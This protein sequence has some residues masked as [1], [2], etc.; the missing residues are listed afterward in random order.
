[1]SVYHDPRSERDVRAR[2]HDIRAG[3]PGQLRQERLATASLLYGP[4]CSLD[5]L[6]RRIARTLP[7]LL[8][9]VRRVTVVPVEQSDSV[10]PDEV[11]LKYDDAMQLGVFS[12]FLVAT[13]AYY[14][15]PRGDPWLVAKV[16]GTD[17][18]AFIAGWRRES[19]SAGHIVGEA[20]CAPRRDRAGGGSGL[21]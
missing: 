3:L 13:P 15:S 8:G 18:W 6:H 10:L 12:R 17:R 1:M 5:E 21:G 2:I 14:W 20:A 19:S 4:L 11:L 7:W 16:D 9:S